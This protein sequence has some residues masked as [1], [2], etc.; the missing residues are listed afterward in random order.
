MDIYLIYGNQSKTLFQ[1]TIEKEFHQCS[2]FKAPQVEGESVQEIH[3]EVKGE[4]FYMTKNTR[5]MFKSY[6]AMVLI[7][8]DKPIYNPGQTVNFRIVALDSNFI[9]LK[10][11]DNNSNRIG[12]WTNV[13]STRLIL[14]LSHEL[15]AEAPL[16]QY[17]IIANSEGKLFHHNFKVQKYVLPKFEITVDSPKEHSVGEEEL[18]L[19]ICGR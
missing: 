1:E 10:Q 15:N 5:V 19:E 14:Q 16:G 4:S 13:T 8:T 2:Q 17:Q 6:D 18:K 11:K 12:Q 9:P 3:V 7:Q